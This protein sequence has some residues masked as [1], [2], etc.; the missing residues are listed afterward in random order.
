MITIKKP[1]NVLFLVSI[2]ALF[3]TFFVFN[4]LIYQKEK[5]K[6]KAQTAKARESKISDNKPPQNE[7]I[8]PTI[9]VN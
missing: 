5:E 9:S 1:V 3:I 7:S 6:A 8:E 4:Y 2:A